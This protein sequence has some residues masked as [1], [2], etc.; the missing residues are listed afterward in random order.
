MN[1][2]REEI[3]LITLSS[4]E[5]LTY[6]N[7]INLLGGSG[8]GEPRFGENEKNLIKSLGEGVYNKVKGNFYS[9][10][11]RDKLL[12][13]LEEL[14]IECVTYLSPLYPEQLK[15]IPCP[16]LTLFCR[17][18]TALLK[19]RL[20]AAVGSRRTP[21]DVLKECEKISFEI[22][23]N[24]TL[25]TGL[26]DGADSSVLKGAL[27][28]GAAVCVLAYGFDHVYPAINKNL[29]K[30]VEER[31]LIITE[32]TPQIKPLPYNFPARNRIIAGLAEGVLAVSAGEKSGALITA[33]YGFEYGR[34]VFA[35]P[36]SPGVPC[37]EGCNLLIREGATLAR[38]A[39]DILTEFG[40]NSEQPQNTVPDLTQ[41]ERAVLDIIKNGETLA[42]AIAQRVGVPVFRL[43]PVLTVLEIKGLISRLGGNRYSANP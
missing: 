38:G 24:F 25:V 8:F 43:I 1:Y 33:R 18:N 3:N 26:A 16:P 22:S 9:Q 14:R 28:R 29:L 31:G 6:K 42:A 12:Q 39:K 41:E 27:K 34:Q 11:Y 15:Q 23:E 20:F 10:A 19:D 13:R 40:F 7:R 5:E 36:Y 17:G 37:G 4:F 30:L 2:T 21:P 35:L 32:Y